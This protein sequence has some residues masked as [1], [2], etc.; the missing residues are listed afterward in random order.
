MFKKKFGGTGQNYRFNVK[1]EGNARMWH[2]MKKKKGFIEGMFLIKFLVIFSLIFTK[3][4]HFVLEQVKRGCL[5]SI[6]FSVFVD[7]L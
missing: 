6:Y 7:F 4:A 2:Y 5:V 1:I 3:Q